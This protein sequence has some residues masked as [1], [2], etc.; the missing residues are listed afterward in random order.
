MI[1]IASF[2][3]GSATAEQALE[4]IQ[5]TNTQFQEKIGITWGIEFN[6]EVIGYYRGFENECGEI[7]YVMRSD[8]KRRGFMLEATEAAIEFGFKQLELKRIIAVTAIENTPSL[9]LLQRLEFAVT[10]EKIEAYT[11]FERFP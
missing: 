2:K 7:G 11:V 3:S 6:G 1:E 5:R 10:E 8:F 4:K 9:E